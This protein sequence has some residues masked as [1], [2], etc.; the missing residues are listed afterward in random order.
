MTGLSPGLRRRRRSLAFGEGG[1]ERPQRPLAA[2]AGILQADCDYGFEP[3]FDPRKKVLPITPAFCF[4][5]AGRGFFELADLA[6]RAREG[7]R[8]NP[9]SRLGRGGVGAL[10][11]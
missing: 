2:F 7:P 6:K 8:G 11:P 1:G 9:F 5:H 10:G 4:A 3:L